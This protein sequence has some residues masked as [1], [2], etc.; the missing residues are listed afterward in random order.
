MRQYVHVVGYLVDTYPEGVLGMATQE[1]VNS[2]F[3]MMMQNF[4]EDKASGVNTVIKFNLKG[5]NGGMYWVKIADGSVEH[6]EGE[7]D[8]GMTV[9]ATAD[10]FYAIATGNMNPMQAYMMGKIK[11]TDIGM[12]MKMIQIFKLG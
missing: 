5:D 7:T 9:E 2:I 3:P 6:G 8:A 12:A 1:E 11:A 4:Q 10:D